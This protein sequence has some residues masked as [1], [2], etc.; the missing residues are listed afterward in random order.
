MIAFGGEKVDDERVAEV[1]DLIDRSVLLAIVTGCIE[2]DAAAALVACRHAWESGVDA[3]RL[4]GE[5][6]GLLRD[7]VV[8]RVAPEAGLVEAADAE[9][10]ALRKLSGQ[11]QEVRLRR[12]FRA[13]LKEQEDLAWAPDPFSV[14]EVALVRLAGLPSGDQVEQLLARIGALERRLRGEGSGGA[15]GGGTPGGGRQSTSS[16][17]SESTP[18]PRA[19]EAE[20]APPEPPPEPE[21]EPAQ[22]MAPEVPSSANTAT[23]QD[24]PASTATSQ[25]APASDA[26]SQDTPLPLVFDR[27][28]AFAQEANRGL[29]AALE[30][31][32][33]LERSDTRV[34]IQLPSGIAAR[35][36]QARVGELA[37]VC[38]SFFGSAVA[39]ELQT[40]EA[41]ASAPGG[42]PASNSEQTPEGRR[43]RQEALNHPAVNDALDILG[44]E[45]LEIK[46]SGD[47]SPDAV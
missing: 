21:P 12:M 22:R 36:L 44:A 6:L 9:V 35:R 42:R 27:L 41:G 10:D 18:R 23:N 25:D 45:I 11:T 32:S 47:A 40:E 28:R 1:L 14:L 37:A 38:E 16:A 39:V 2:G 46:P 20:A 13:L 17:G 33:L 4:G 7:L 34:R 19:P 26:A 29:F 30:G 5:L 43:K 24:A 8:L 31:G 15:G 3:K